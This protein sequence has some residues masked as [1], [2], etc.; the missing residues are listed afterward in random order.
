MQTDLVDHDDY[1][2]QQQAGEGLSLEED[3]KDWSN[4]VRIRYPWENLPCEGD[5]PQG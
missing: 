2:W 4:P 1:E 5:D 3:G